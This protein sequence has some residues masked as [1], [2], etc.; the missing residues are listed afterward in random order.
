MRAPSIGG[1]VVDVIY[2]ISY[3]CPSPFSR[4][5]S[6]LVSAIVFGLVCLLLGR[7]SVPSSGL[8]VHSPH[9][10]SGTHGKYSLCSGRCARWA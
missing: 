3:W 1:E 7:H 2:T 4:A 10:L 9:V 8:T 5:Q 6:C